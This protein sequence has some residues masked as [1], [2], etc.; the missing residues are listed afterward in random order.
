[1]REVSGVNPLIGPA[2]YSIGYTKDHVAAVACP[3]N[4][5]SILAAVWPPGEQGLLRGNPLVGIE[6]EDVRRS[7]EAAS[8]GRE[9]Y[10]NSIG[11]G[12]GRS[13]RRRQL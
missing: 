12:R 7:I 5:E 6:G 2:A 10:P 11:E 9:G 8:F 1:M 4:E 3:A 13:G